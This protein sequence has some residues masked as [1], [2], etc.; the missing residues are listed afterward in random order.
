MAIQ[1]GKEEEE[2]EAEERG[3]RREDRA[4]S[5][6]GSYEDRTQFS[7]LSNKEE[8]S[9]L[10]KADADESVSREPA[11]VRPAEV[12]VIPVDSHM[13][14]LLQQIDS[15]DIDTLLSLEE[16]EEITTSPIRY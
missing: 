11:Q 10:H 2:A 15:I 1:R 13:A 12:G 3:K 16:D 6:V 4:V 14:S 8:V 7:P 5:Q 9:M